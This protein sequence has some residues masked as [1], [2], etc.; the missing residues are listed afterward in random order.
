MP[1][2]IATRKNVRSKLKE[3]FDAAMVGVGKPVFAV[4]DH[5]RRKLDGESPVVLI[6]SGGWAPNIRW[7]GTQKFRTVIRIVVH[8]YV[9]DVLEDGSWTEPDVEDKLDEV[10]KEIADV[11]GDNQGVIGYWN[12]IEFDDSQSS[13]MPVADVGGV[14]YTRESF[15][16]FAEVQDA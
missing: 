14:R 13:I 4:Y 7:I 9:L 5:E 8:V 16:L 11:I 12:R 6:L 10:A 15:V 2:D 3:L 1:A